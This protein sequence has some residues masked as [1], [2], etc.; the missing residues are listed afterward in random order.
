[1]VVILMP[2][3]RG[4]QQ[5][6]EPVPLSLPPRSCLALSV[7]REIHGCLIDIKYL[8]KGNTEPLRILS[9]LSPISSAPLALPPLAGP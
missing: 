8:L 9:F 2:V 6:E 7:I 5:T 3:K 4:S 1:M